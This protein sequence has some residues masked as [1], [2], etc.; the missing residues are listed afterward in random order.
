MN[1]YKL[2]VAY[3]GTDYT[4]WQIQSHT[5]S[6]AAVLQ[7]RFKKVFGKTIKIV[8]ASRTDAGV[9]ALANVVS[10]STDLA[11]STEKMMFAWNNA[12]PENI[13]LLSLHK[14]H[15]NFQPRKNVN[16]KT[17]WYHVFTERP[18]PFFARYGYY[19][20]QSLDIE[21]LKKALAIFV[22]KHDFRAFTCDERKV[23]VRTIDSITLEYVAEIKAYRI[24]V[25]GRSFL[26]HMIRRIVGAC[27][28]VASDPTLSLDFLRMVL[29]KKDPN[30]WLPNAPAQGLTL[31]SIL[32]E[33]NS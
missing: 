13:S 4:G 12:L 15:A 2:V 19:H 21:K 5:L 20:Y 6:I 14:V 31:H 27:L 33:H 7:N 3:D 18:L 8:T 28:K 16:Y 17:Y 11:I 22:G 26:R 29:E 25:K 23:T 24:I 9:H 32:Y 1:R 10:F 30:H